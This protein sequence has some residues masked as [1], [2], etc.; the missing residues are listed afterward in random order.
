VDSDQQTRLNSLAVRLEETFP[1]LVSVERKRAGFFSK[2]E[3]VASLKV[4]LEPFEYVLEL[5]PRR[6][7]VPKKAKVVRSIRI[8]TEEIPIGQWMTEM[9]EALDAYAQKNK[10]IRFAIDDFMF[11]Q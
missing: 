3:N 7:I 11:F 9:T 6:G 1:G 8:K 5:Q 4:E 2:H 10:Q